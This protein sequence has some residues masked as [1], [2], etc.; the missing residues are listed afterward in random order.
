MKDQYTL[1]SVG[2]ANLKLLSCL[3]EL[4]SGAQFQ[5]LRAS[6]ASLAAERD[7]LGNQLVKNQPSVGQ[8]GF[9]QWPVTMPKDLIESQ[10]QVAQSFVNSVLDVQK[11]LGSDGRTAFGE[12]QSEVVSILGNVDP[13]SLIN[14]WKNRYFGPFASLFTI[15]KK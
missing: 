5:M 2:Q 4:T 8:V 6:L 12:W 14:E 7:A 13:S 11:V 1:V 3:A 15:G 10:T 9:G